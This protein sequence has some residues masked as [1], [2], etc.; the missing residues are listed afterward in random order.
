[1]RR[2][3]EWTFH[4]S[5]PL[6]NIFASAWSSLL[7]LFADKFEVA[8]LS[9]VKLKAFGCQHFIWTI[10][11]SIWRLAPLMWAFCR[12]NYLFTRYRPHIPQAKF[13][14]RYYNALRVIVFV[15]QACQLS[16]SSLSITDFWLLWWK[17]SQYPLLIKSFLCLQC[18]VLNVALF[19]YHRLVY[20][21]FAHLLS[22][23]SCLIT[24]I[25][26]RKPLPSKFKRKPQFFVHVCWL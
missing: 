24:T 21:G 12:L 19:L 22:S 6:I 18:L 26:F 2:V 11:K 16:W 7:L 17:L 5:F 3:L 1:M 8:I 15:V 9:V 10:D 13:A 20:K 4:N 25:S 14:I 23:V